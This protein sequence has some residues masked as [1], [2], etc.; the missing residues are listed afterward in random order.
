MSERDEGAPDKAT[1]GSRAPAVGIALSGGGSR[2]IAFHLGCLRTLHRLGILE[3]SKVLSTVSGGSVIGAMYVIRRSGFEEF[4]DDVRAV[5]RSGLVRPAL[6]TA[7]T[8]P[9]G[10][11]A[12]LRLATLA[13]AWLWLLPFHAVGGLLR[14]SYAADPAASAGAIPGS[15]L[16]RR[17]ASRTTILRRTMDGLL[18]GGK[19]LGDLRP[20]G[21]RWVAVATELTTGSA[22]YFGRREAGSYRIGKVDPAKIKVAHAVAASAAYP[23]LLPALDD[24][25]TFLRRDGSLAAQRVI[26]TDG[27]IYDNLGL[28]PLWP[29][30]DPEISIGVEK[31][32]AIVACRAG[33]GLRT[34]DPG[35]F[36]KSRMAAA[37]NTVHLRA[38]NATMKRLFDL[39]AA[40]RL[41]NFALPYLDQE[42]GRLEFAPADLVRRTEVVGYPTNFSAMPT[43]WIEKLSKRGE[44]LT[45]AVIRQH[46]PDLLPPGWRPGG[47]AGSGEETSRDRQPAIQPGTAP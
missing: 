42:D 8:S 3:R 31:L 17:S 39:K 33:Y 7:L 11:K 34:I 29:D 16:P 32:D 35:I 37:F 27:G 28:S 47:C 12:A 5:L 43:E 2:A 18:Y 46:A 38:Q 20:D 30:R 21:P 14:G 19:L 36:V 6:R 40:G 41:A 26:L 15:R 44:Q 23:V 24:V 45:L 10:A 1:A 4:E 9:E 22:F 25:P 13:G